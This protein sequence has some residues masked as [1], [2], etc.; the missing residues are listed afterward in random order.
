M[1]TIPDTTNYMIAGYTVFSIVMVSYLVSLYTRWRK[2]EREQQI[3][4]EIAKK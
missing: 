2:L 3:L 1:G 4:D